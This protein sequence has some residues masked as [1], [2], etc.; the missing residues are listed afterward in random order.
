MAGT[1]GKKCGNIADP[2]KRRK[3]MKGQQQEVR[4]GRLPITKGKKKRPPTTR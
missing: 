4:A 2:V 3:C 1:T